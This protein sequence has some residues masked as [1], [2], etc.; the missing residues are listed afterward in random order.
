[1]QVYPSVL[2]KDF[3]EF[4][5]KINLVKGL[6]D[7]VHLDIMDG[8]FV[9]NS[10]IYDIDKINSFDWGVDYELHLMVK[11]SE[12]EKWLNTNA[13]RIIFH[14]EA[15]NQKPKTKNQN[16]KAKIKNLI[17]KIRERKKEVGIAV[18][19]ETDIENI[20]PF[21]NELDLVLI[22]SIKPGWSG[23][24]F[25]PEALEKVKKLRDKK[26]NGIIEIDGGVNEENIDA[27]ANSGAGAVSVA[28]AIWKDK[29]KIKDQISK[30]QIKN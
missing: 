21:L 11:E 6:V 10:T 29:S 4:E 13:K 23:Q 3:E 18:N 14:Y 27:I 20:F 9:E 30:L 16:H 24:K 8:V 25:T 1:M 19:M 7:T 5:A 22:M 15:I 28:S 2:V 12:I 26:F 17:N